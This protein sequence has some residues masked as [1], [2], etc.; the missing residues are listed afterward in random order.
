MM[1][2]MPTS[3]AGSATLELEALLA[4]AS[5]PEADCEVL[6]A[7]PFPGVV[8]GRAALPE[9]GTSGVTLVGTVV[10]GAAALCVPVIA[11]G[12]SSPTDLEVDV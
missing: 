5:G 7:D 12:I 1:M 9:P 11:A 6:P 3:V 10:L 4:D 2:R 8:S